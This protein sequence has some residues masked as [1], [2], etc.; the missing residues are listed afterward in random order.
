MYLRGTLK[1][2]GKSSDKK[3]H[4][5]G[6]KF[7]LC[8]NAKFCVLTRWCPPCCQ[9]ARLSDSPFVRSPIVR[10]FVCQGPIVRRP[11]F[12]KIRWQKYSECSLFRKFIVPNVHFSE[13]SIPNVQFRMLNPYVQFRMF[14]SENSVPI[15]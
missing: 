12:Q 15:V 2:S 11:D 13:F 5:W 9:M 7:E 14:N 6:Q 1:L 10:K 3:N 8:E 4:V